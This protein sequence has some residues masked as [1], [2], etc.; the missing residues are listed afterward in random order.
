MARAVAQAWAG[1][2][3]S[4]ATPRDAWIDAGL[5]VYMQNRL[6]REV[7]GEARATTDRILAERTVREDLGQMARPDQAARSRSA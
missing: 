6:V 5:A 2:L 1:D 3:V 4:G 7:Y